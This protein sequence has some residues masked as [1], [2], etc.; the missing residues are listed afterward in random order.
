MDTAKLLEALRS[1]RSYH[2]QI[3]HVEKIPSRPAVFGELTEPIRGLVGQAI[4]T[5]GLKR[6]YV[7]QVEA[8][9]A[10]RR[11]ESLSLIHI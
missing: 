11:G 5:A 2:G 7:H 6:F 8:I 9:E 10:A 1:S 4:A 3:C